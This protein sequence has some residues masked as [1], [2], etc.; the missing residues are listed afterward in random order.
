MSGMHRIM[1]VTAIC[2]VILQFTA[3]MDPLSHLTLV[4]Q[5]IIRWRRNPEVPDLD[6]DDDGRSASPVYISDLSD[7]LP[8]PAQPESPS[9]TTDTGEDLLSPKSQRALQQYLPTQG[10]LRDLTRAWS[11]R[12]TAS[13]DARIGIVSVAALSKNAFDQ[14]YT[15]VSDEYSDISSVTTASSSLVSKILRTSLQNGCRI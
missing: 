4:A 15:R 5:P 11:G 9:V 10:L 6:T 13:L 12:R 7:R 1:F 3:A 8:R 2:C 14:R